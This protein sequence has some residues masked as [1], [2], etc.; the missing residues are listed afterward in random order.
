MYINIKA[1][2]IYIGDKI[3]LRVTILIRDRDR[4]ILS[5][6]MIFQK[7]LLSVELLFKFLI[8]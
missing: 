5:E 2:C 6:P 4:L 1:L 3:I 8:R 7:E